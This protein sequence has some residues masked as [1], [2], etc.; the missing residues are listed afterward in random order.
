MQHRALSLL[1]VTTLFF[2]CA[3]GEVS[4]PASNPPPSTGGTSPPV[5]P[6]P[7]GGEPTT[8]PQGTP[9]PT[10]PGVTPTPTPQ[11]MPPPSTDPSTMPPSTTP[12]P[13]GAPKGPF[14]CSLVIGIQ[15]TAD[16]FNGG[17]EKMVDGN[18]WE[19]MAVHSG[20]VNYWAD[21]KHN[22]WNTKP[23]S[24][25]AMNAD[26]PDRVILTALYL[27]WMSATVDEWVTQ[28]TAA[29]KNLQAK[30]SNLKNVELATFIRSPEDKPC[31]GG[32]EFKSFIRPEQDM[33]YDKM[34]A[35]FAPG[36]VTV[37]P[38]V[39]V[40]SCDDYNKN[41]PHLPGGPAARMATK[42]AAVYKG[43]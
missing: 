42:M 17:F 23:S 7:S 21:P 22:I 41:P 19:L 20:F 10:P 28:L 15:A 5:T 37:A 32:M 11:P 30:Y 36:L 31:P 8:P 2:G 25:C 9:Q 26:N 33:A 18:K 14:T 35:L 6:P 1:C 38:K 4:P 3:S 13:A 16:W 12:P 29:I 40:D 24:A 34:P 27:H 43:E 39:R